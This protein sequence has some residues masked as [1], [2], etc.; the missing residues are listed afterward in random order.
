MRPAFSVLAPSV[1]ICYLNLYNQL[2]NRG[3][4]STHSY[5]WSEPMKFRI[6]AV[7][8]AVAAGGCLQPQ[9][10]NSYVSFKLVYHSDTRGFYNPCG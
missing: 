10:N 2:V 9:Q 4:D 6:F 3:H 8:L 1:Y 7:L 5:Q